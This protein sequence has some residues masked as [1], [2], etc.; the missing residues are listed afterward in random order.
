MQLHSVSSTEILHL[1][2]DGTVQRVSD[3]PYFLTVSHTTV[4][5]FTAYRPIRNP[6]ETTSVGGSFARSESDVCLRHI[7]REMRTVLG[8]SVV[9]QVEDES[10]YE[11]GYQ[12]VPSIN[13]AET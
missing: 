1:S 13:I 6:Y 9:S 7:Q 11:D 8:N 3:I 4:I 12:T 10:R 2:S 5:T